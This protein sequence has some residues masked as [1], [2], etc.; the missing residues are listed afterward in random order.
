MISKKVIPFIEKYKDLIEEEN[1]DA[2]Y[3]YSVIQETDVD[4]ADLTEAF[5]EAGIDPMIYLHETIP[6]GYAEGLPLTTVNIP[7]GIFSV[8]IS[9]FSKCPDLAS[10]HLPKSL[11][12][13]ESSAFFQCSKLININLPENISY[14]GPGAFQSCQKLKNIKLPNSLTDIGLLCF[15]DCKNL[16]SVTFGNNLQ[17]IKN[18]AFSYCTRLSSLIFPELL[19][20][21]YGRAFE[22]CNNL[23]ELT[24]LGA[25]PPKIVEGAFIN[26]PIENIHFNGSMITWVNNVNVR[27]F[28]PSTQ[29]RV[30]CIDGELIKSVGD[31]TWKTSGGN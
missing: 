29:I 17:T 24:F 14:I 7:D 3:L 16:E 23:R 15:L 22:G 8:G 19:E 1:F 4:P 2:L 28:D 20:V 10:V 6:Y 13:I 5:L 9:A 27:A 25:I 30:V 26:C 18:Q 21:I 11:T 31:F 12:S